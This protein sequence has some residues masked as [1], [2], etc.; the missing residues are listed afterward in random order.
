MTRAAFALATLVALAGS[1]CGDDTPTAPSENTTPPITTPVTTTFTAVIGPNGSLSRSFTAQVPGMAS[2]VVTGISPPTALGLGIGIPRPDGAGC[3]LT[4][5]TVSGDLSG[6]EIAGAV[7]TG[8][9]CVQVYAPV[10]AADTVRFDVS[11]THP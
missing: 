1:G 6:V 11:L 7:H 10:T 9:F 8:V 2:A 5:S 4:Y 3:L